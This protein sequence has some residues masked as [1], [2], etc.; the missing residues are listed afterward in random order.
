MV[1]VMMVK[2]VIMM[3]MEQ[4]SANTLTKLNTMTLNDG[5][6]GCF[7]DAVPE[8]E[9]EEEG[10]VVTIVLA[11]LACLLLLGGIGLNLFKKK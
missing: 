8:L 7:A 11:F 5:R 10:S 6:R 9:K 4:K 3:T 1:I 2:I